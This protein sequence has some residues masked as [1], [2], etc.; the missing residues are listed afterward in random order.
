MSP[1][2]IILPIEVMRLAKMNI[3]QMSIWIVR[4]ARV[5]KRRFGIVVFNGL[6]LWRRFVVVLVW[7]RGRSIAIIVD[8]LLDALLLLPV[9]LLVVWARVD[10]LVSLGLIVDRFLLVGHLALPFSV[11]ASHHFGLLNPTEESGSDT[12]WEHLEGHE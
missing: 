9:F 10:R 1:Q 2:R 3:N 12:N 11:V 7:R 4:N 5:I 8:D 6:F